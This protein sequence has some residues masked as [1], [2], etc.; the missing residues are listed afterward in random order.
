M[1][2]S[3]CKQSL[4]VGVAG[5]YHLVCPTAAHCCYL[6][7]FLLSVLLDI[8][9]LQN[10]TAYSSKSKNPF[11][12]YTH[13]I[14]VLSVKMFH[15]LDMDEGHDK[16]VNSDYSGSLVTALTFYCFVVSQ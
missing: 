5:S 10:L 1:L 11:S 13:L 2:I 16:S 14:L 4:A 6:S 15:L 12:R 9:R 8:A 3:I 7:N